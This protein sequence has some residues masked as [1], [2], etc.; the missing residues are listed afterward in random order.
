MSSE[1]SRRSGDGRRGL[2][3]ESLGTPGP[4]SRRAN[5]FDGYDRSSEAQGSEWLPGYGRRG[6]G[7]SGRRG[8][9]TAR[10]HAGGSARGRFT[11][12]GPKGYQRSDERIRED[13]SDLLE[14][15][16]DLDASEIV[17]EVRVGEV[18][19]EGTVPDRPSKRLAEDLI[20]DVSGVKQVHN[21]LRIAANGEASKP[22]GERPS[23]E[24]PSG[25]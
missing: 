9:T 23:G 22:S 3:R 19:L 15:D 2:E 14:R 4:R 18:T 24:R 17:V 21:R 16:G 10:G 5:A 25:S 12:K 8:G 1:P 11:G 13:V 7:D 20:E 6:E